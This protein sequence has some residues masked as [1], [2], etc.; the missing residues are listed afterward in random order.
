MSKI[1]GKDT[2][3]NAL[4]NF[5]ELHDVNKSN[6]LLKDLNY[7]KTLEKYEETT[8]VVSFIDDA[9]DNGPK[10]IDV[11][12]LK[13]GANWSISS[14]NLL[15]NDAA[16]FSEFSASSLWDS[17]QSL[18]FSSDDSDTIIGDRST[19]T[20][21]WKFNTSIS[22]VH[23]IHLSNELYNDYLSGFSND[24]IFS[25]TGILSDAMFG[26]LGASRYENTE[27]TFEDDLIQPTFPATIAEQQ[28]SMPRLKA[29]N[30]T[31][32]I[33]NTRFY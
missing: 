15:T 2:K 20:H 23:C 31:Y 28:I 29:A 17:F 6:V 1:N 24:L 30:I 13:S 19:I 14:H 26:I 9:V 22:A 33:I 21:P 5:N 11:Y 12:T 25:V 16:T 4:T 10:F 3:Y 27:L 8:S 32:S 18:F 7:T